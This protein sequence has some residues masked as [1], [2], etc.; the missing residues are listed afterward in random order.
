MQF[1]LATGDDPERD[2]I[3]FSG[4]KISELQVDKLVHLLGKTKSNVPAYLR[5]VGVKSLREISESNFDT[6]LSM[7][8]K[9]LATLKSA[10]TIHEPKK[11]KQ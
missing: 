6:A 4:N 10:D 1:A 8:E 5:V 9:K 3:N 7:L 2:S 11:E